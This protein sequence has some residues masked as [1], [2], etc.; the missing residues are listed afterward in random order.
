MPPPISRATV[1]SLLLLLSWISLT[2]AIVNITLS[3]DTLEAASSQIFNININYDFDQGSSSED[4]KFDSIKS[5]LAISP[6]GSW[7]ITG[8][9]CI[10]LESAAMGDSG[11]NMGSGTDEMPSVVG[12]TGLYYKIAV[13]PFNKDPNNRTVHGSSRGTVKY[14][15]AF[16]LTHTSGQFAD[17][18]RHN[19]GWPAFLADYI[20]CSD[21]NCVRDCYS[22]SYPHIKGDVACDPEQ[23]KTYDCMSKC[24][25][26]RLPTFEDIVLQVTG[27]SI[28]CTGADPTAA[29]S[30]STTGTSSWTTTS[31]TPHTATIT[32]TDPILVTIL[33]SLV[34]GQAMT[35][36]GSGSSP[37]T[38]GSRPAETSPKKPSSASSHQ[39][40]RA[41]LGTWLGIGIFGMV[42]GNAL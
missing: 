15:N 23:R 27:N 24:P 14:S 1:V 13:M 7:D 16:T 11:F 31:A 5:Y 26:T 40:T 42:V 30:S 10:L 33:A 19:D 6:G 39:I 20:G 36:T 21:Y 3:S 4:K 34:G 38:S 8:P 29:T 25:Q 37:T 18:E 12:E 2:L 9:S 17:F 28:N 22:A 41:D 32:D 35:S